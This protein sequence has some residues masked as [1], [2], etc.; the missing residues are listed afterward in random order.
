[1]ALTWG[2]SRDPKLLHFP[3]F[4]QLFSQPITREEGC[5]TF[6]GSSPGLEQDLWLPS[7]APSPSLWPLR[8]FLLRSH[9][10]VHLPPPPEQRVGERPVAAVLTPVPSLSGPQCCLHGCREGASRQGWTEGCVCDSGEAHG[11]GRKQPFHS[12]QGHH[13]SFPSRVIY[14]PGLLLIGCETQSQPVAT[15]AGLGF[16]SCAVQMKL[17]PSQSN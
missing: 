9:L 3:S 13:L 12:H 5:E 14:I 15:S 7:M 1:M 8:A 4:P 11:K 16:P 10:Y 6:L 2:P 17:Y